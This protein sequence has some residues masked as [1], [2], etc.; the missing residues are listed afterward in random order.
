M[1][2]ESCLPTLADVI[3][4]SETRES[5]PKKRAGGVQR[6]HQISAIAIG[7]SQIADEYVKFV[8]CAE[9]ERRLEIQS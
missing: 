8:L 2:L 1:V 9:I 6:L 3:F 4:H 7:Q 5:N